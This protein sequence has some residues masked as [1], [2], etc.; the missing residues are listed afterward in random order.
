MQDA[1]S[2]I[3]RT[4]L[5]RLEELKPG[6][7]SELV[8]GIKADKEAIIKSGQMNPDLEAVFGS[9]EALLRQCSPQ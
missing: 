4:L 8:S 2:Y 7:L 6:L 9:A 1:T 3:L 5:P